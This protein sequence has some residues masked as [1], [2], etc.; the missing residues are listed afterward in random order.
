MTNQSFMGRVDYDT[1][2]DEQGRFVFERVTP[3]AIS[4][5]R[6]VE[7]RDH[8]GWT[9]SNPVFVEV[10]TG[11]TLH[12]Q[13][14]GNGRPV[15]GR[16]HVPQGFSLADLVAHESR[17]S[18]RRREP[19]LPDDYPDY[20][21]GQQRAWYDRF[22]KTPEGKAC[23]QGER[24]YAVDLHDDGSFRVEDV[25]AGNYRFELHFRGRHQQDE[26]GLFAAAHAT[27]AVPTIPGGRSDEPLDMG[28]VK[29]EVFRL[30]VLK[31]GDQVPAIT[32]NLAD[33]RPL[34]LGSL[35]GKFVLLHFW[36]TYRG[37]DLPVLKETYRPSAETPASS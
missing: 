33:G 30:N 19:R 34:D 31:P 36:D 15:T 27:V 12:V 22:Y 10:G 32:R 21:D 37:A 9:P 5:Y 1:M 7:D 6:Y 14:G 26:G 17:L 13:V 3:G 11:Q 24:Q 29:L 2:S 23:Y 20:S 28:A 25:P 8:R 35:R 4:F 18:S 16:L